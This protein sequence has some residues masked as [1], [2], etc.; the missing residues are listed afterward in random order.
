VEMAVVSTNM[1]DF[2]RVRVL[3]DASKPL[4]RFVTLAPE[5]C[6][7]LLVQILYEKMPRFCAFCG[8]RSHVHLECGTGEFAKEDLQY[9]T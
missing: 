5:G 6:R 4:I 2:H 9:G 8:R 1:G 3:M 7:D